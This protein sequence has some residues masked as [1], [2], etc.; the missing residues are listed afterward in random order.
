[1]SANMQTLKTGQIREEIRKR[2]RVF[3]TSVVWASDTTFV[4]AVKSDLLW[5]L[6]K[7]RPGDTFLAMRDADGDLYITAS[8]EV[9]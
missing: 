2:G 5:Q 3:V 7:A 4:Q 6:E 1:M 9:L 8:A